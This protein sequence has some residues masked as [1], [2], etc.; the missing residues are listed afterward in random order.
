MTG[1][2][3]DDTQWKSS[4]GNDVD[5]DD[6]DYDYDDGDDSLF[7]LAITYYVTKATVS[8]LSITQWH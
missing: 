8:G 4:V 2:S 5:Y 6:D 3:C 1:P 7:E